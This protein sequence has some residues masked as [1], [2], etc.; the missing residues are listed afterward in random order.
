[1]FS[2]PVDECLI[3]AGS[4]GWRLL[5]SVKDAQKGSPGCDLTLICCKWQCYFL[6]CPISVIYALVLCFVG[7]TQVCEHNESQELRS[8]KV[9]HGR[10][11]F[12]HLH[13]KSQLTWLQRTSHVFW[14]AHSQTK[15]SNTPPFHILWEMASHSWGAWQVQN[16]CGK[17][18][19]LN[20][21]TVARIQHIVSARNVHRL[22]YGDNWAPN[23]FFFNR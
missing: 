15:Q 10:R 14:T 19:R 7:C 3:A 20:P 5:A 6:F 2:V 11:N 9:N 18:G 23:V 1:M 17:T 8:M 13:L 21:P 12:S 22:Q 4:G 16:L